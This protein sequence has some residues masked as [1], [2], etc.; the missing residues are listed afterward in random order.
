MQAAMKPRR[1]PVRGPGLPKREA[2]RTASGQSRSPAIQGD[3]ALEQYFGALADLPLLEAAQEISLAREIEALEIAHW[4]ALLS[5][6]PALA[7]V[8]SAIAPHLHGRA[9]KLEALRGRAA[10]PAAGHAR[11]RRSNASLPPTLRQAAR[12][13]RRLDRTREGLHAADAAVQ[14]AFSGNERA[15]A[16]LARVATA[17]AAEQRV[18][19]RFIAANLRLVIAMAQRYRRSPL[20]LEDLI[21]EGNL[22]LMRAVD[23]Y[24]H[25]RG[26]RF[27]TYATWW[28]RH[29]LNRAV[30]DKARLVRIPVHALDD[31]ARVAR[32]VDSIETTTGAK[33]SAD[34][35]AART[36]MSIT[37]LAQ[38][39]QNARL[40]H[41]MSL[42]RGFGRDD[43]QTLHDR[44][45]PAE[46]SEIEE[47]L[48]LARWSENLPRLLNVLRPIEAAIV[49][50]RFGLDGDEELTLKQIGEKYNLSRER[51]RQLQVDALA[52]LR[53]A[54][55]GEL[56]PAASDQSA[57]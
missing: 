31:V 35:L 40:E 32:A 37:K 47:Y 4:Y 27:S 45:A 36:G 19:N 1:A 11:A 46:S 52:K 39:K 26:L 7:V 21:Q 22:G 10:V 41:P 24:D 57:A 5:A 38:L 33:P 2:R 12:Q 43:D 20:A 28:I 13:L 17:A 14:P 3:G 48:D 53:S 44:L 15:R 50:F 34:E 23:R 49:R 29:A 16:Y 54:I 6:R 30:S 56:D 51:I 42:D 9:T 55:T 18:K 8:A 25:R